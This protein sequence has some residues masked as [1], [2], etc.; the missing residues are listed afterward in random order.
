MTRLCYSDF[1]GLEGIVKDIK[2][3]QF[4][5]KREQIERQI[6]ANTNYIEGARNLLGARHNKVLE[7]MKFEMEQL[8][9]QAKKESLDLTI[10]QMESEAQ[11]LNETSSLIETYGAPSRIPQSLQESLD[12]RVSQIKADFEWRKKG[13]EARHMKQLRELGLQ[14]EGRRQVLAEERKALEDIVAR[15]IHLLDIERAKVEAEE[16]QWRYLQKD[17]N[18]LQELRDMS[19]E[20]FYWVLSRFDKFLSKRV[21]QAIKKTWEGSSC[22]AKEPSLKSAVVTPQ[23]SRDGKPSPPMCKEKI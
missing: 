22:I 23:A 19:N 3:D 17:E 20:D 16:A 7:E 15:E 8:I 21:E 11:V 10:E 6:E 5:A 12:A 18:R 14:Q 4:E 1:E 9:T 13:M 2:E